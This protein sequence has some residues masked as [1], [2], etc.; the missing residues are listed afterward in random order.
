MTDRPHPEL[1]PL[2]RQYARELAQI[3]PSTRLDARIDQL[4]AGRREETSPPLTRAP[5]RAPRRLPGALLAACMA[6][7]AIGLGVVTGVALERRRTITVP[8]SP[9]RALDTADGMVSLTPPTLWPADSVSLQMPVQLSP[10]GTLVPVAEAS[11][12]AGERYWVDIVVSNDG[13]VRIER[14]IPAR[15]ESDVPQFPIH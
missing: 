8:L 10:R 7:A 12:D 9:P 6:L 2:L 14:I 3:E 15:K 11:P 4:V 1:T 5:A 13:T